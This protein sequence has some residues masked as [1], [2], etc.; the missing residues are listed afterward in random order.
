MIGSAVIDDFE[1]LT[2][3]HKMGSE[4]ETGPQGDSEDQQGERPQGNFDN[5]D[6]PEDCPTCCYPCCYN[7]CVC[8]IC[9]VSPNYHTDNCGDLQSGRES[10]YD[11]QVE[12]DQRLDNGG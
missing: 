4:M 6:G 11:A 8:G 2:V 9:G 1:S 7:C 10:D 3:K 12:Q 5:Y